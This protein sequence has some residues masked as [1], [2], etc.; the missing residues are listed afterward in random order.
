MSAARENF[1]QNMRHVGDTDIELLLRQREKKT[2]ERIRRVLLSTYNADDNKS[3][4]SILFPHSLRSSFR[5]KST[6]LRVFSL[7]TWI[8]FLCFVFFQCCHTGA[9]VAL[10]LSSRRRSQVVRWEDE[11]PA[12]MS[13]F[14]CTYTSRRVVGGRYTHSILA[15]VLGCTYGHS[16]HEIW[17]ARGAG[18]TLRSVRTLH[19]SSGDVSTFCEVS[20]HLAHT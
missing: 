20:V 15:S 12:E 9:T 17:D 11:K 8:V 5:Q 4:L 14:R 13:L 10:Q 2:V 7:C 19:A 16:H 6:S 1:Q 3:D 18:V